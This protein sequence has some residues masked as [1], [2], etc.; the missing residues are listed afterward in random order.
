MQTPST[1][2]NLLVGVFALQLEFISSGQF[3]GAISNWV[4]DKN[5]SLESVLI[6]Q[7]SL[8]PRDADMLNEMVSKH[9]S[10]SNGDARA[11]TLPETVSRIED[12]LTSIG[13]A[14]LDMFLHML[15]QRSEDEH[16]VAPTQDIPGDG[17]RFQ[18]M[19]KMAEG[20][21]GVISRARDMQLNRDVAL[22]EIQPKHADS[23]QSRLRFTLEAEVTGGLEHP[24]IVPVYS[25]G[26]DHH[27]RPF[28]AMRL[29]RGESLQTVIR[30]IHDHPAAIK[31]MGTNVSTLRRLLARLV[32]VCNTLAY[33]H[34]RGVMHRD[35]KPS[36]IMMGKFGETLIVDWGLAKA[37][38][39]GTQVAASRLADQIHDPVADTQSSVSGMK[40]REPMLEPLGSGSSIE[41]IDG[42]RLG[43]PSYMSPEQAGR[44]S[45]D[46][47]PAADVYSLGAT[48]Y[49]LLCGR[50][51]HRRGEGK[52]GQ[53]YLPVRRV[54]RTI[55]QGL[56][57]ICEK[58][59]AMQPEHR[60]KD[61]AEMG[62]DIECW[63]ADDDIMAWDEPVWEKTRRW[64]RNHQSWFA[65]LLAAALV[66]SVALGVI[67]ALTNGNNQRL[68]LA[69]AREKKASEKARANEIV[70]RQQSEI[71]LDALN[72]IV[73]E[74]QGRLKTVPAAQSARRELLKTA[75][76]GLEKLAS[77]FVDEGNVSRNESRAL[78][79]LSGILLTVGDDESL[80]TSV[81]DALDVAVRAVSSAE[82]RFQSQLN[83]EQARSDLF[84]ALNQLCQVHERLGNS[85][86]LS[87]A[88][89]RMEE[90][91]GGIEVNAKASPKLLSMLAASHSRMAQL[92]RRLGSTKDAVKSC[93]QAIEILTRLIEENSRVDNEANVSEWQRQLASDYDVRGI[94]LDQLAQRRKAMS[95][96]NEAISITS[97]LVEK[98]PDNVIDVRARS[99][100]LSNLATVHLNDN[101][102][103]KAMPIL[104]ESLKIRE[105]LLVDDPLNEQLVRD[106]SIV[107]D[108][109]AKTL[110]KLDRPGE[111]LDHYERSVDLAER[112][113]ASDPDN[114][115][116]QFELAKEYTNLATVHFTAGDF[117][118]SLELHMQARSID[119][120]MSKKDPSNLQVQKDL[121]ICYL[122]IGMTH[123]KLG[124]LRASSEAYEQSLTAN[125]QVLTLDPDNSYARHYL[126][127]VYWSLADV[128]RQ[129]GNKQLCVNTFNSGIEFAESVL[130]SEPGNA[131]ALAE[132][133]QLQAE[134]ALFLGDIGKA[135]KLAGEFGRSDPSNADNWYNAAC[136]YSLAIKKLMKHENPDRGAIDELERFAV[137]ALENS[138][139]AGYDDFDNMRK[140]DDLLPLSGLPE[141]RALFPEAVE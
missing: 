92:H 11:I 24:G 137:E 133:F 128:Y 131:S 135:T 83:D 4:R 80:G 103:E 33:A 10:Q 77:Q 9:V 49:E 62:A 109:V 23:T 112:L 90:L 57:A 86:E 46:I 30:K 106:V 64:V 58:A 53:P 120:A 54:N 3:V 59:M 72:S 61:P 18:I 45:E 17:S 125:R 132:R 26:V 88:S 139:E 15:K 98:S 55:P 82:D 2:R 28:Y 47:G 5:R 104:E 71:A 6:E 41:T 119:E 74:V 87:L 35:I 115:S 101:N 39:D 13:D 78:V 22:K 44:I 107:N 48:L 29:I 76:G 69:A 31:W 114:A 65:S 126:S 67:A 34:S 85:T 37:V 8:D 134:L 42:D 105:S 40:T 32:Y 95:D 73:F 75:L 94:A 38:N 21:L 7:G 89:R 116:A 84:G 43:T 108:V 36:N 118:K 122:N 121:G 127:W 25:L 129:L 100:Y 140:D 113:A 130:D 63:M 66:A 68:K 99:V 70:A 79:E 20:G 93:D 111:A 19:E 136:I 51:P 96:I 1:E 52:P 27:G 56:A 91:V 123:F 124:Q 60:Y 50:P 102:P 81:Q 110:V 97:R 16:P 117:E 141:F 12:D 138:V 14:D